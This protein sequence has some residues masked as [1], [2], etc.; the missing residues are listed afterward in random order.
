M[1]V[2]GWQGPTP[3]RLALAERVRVLRAD[4]VTHRAIASQLGIS[5]SYASELDVDPDGSRARARK[6][7]YQGVCIDCG[8]PTTGGEGVS[9]QPRRCDA[10]QR[11]YQRSDEGRAAVT[12]WTRD[13]I[14]EAI[15]WWVN[16]YGEP[17]AIPDWSPSRAS[18]LFD[19]ARTRR[20]ERLIAEKRV[21]WSTTVICHF[22]SWNAGIV[23][24]G[25]E[26]RAN[27]G[28]RENRARQRGAR[29]TALNA[30]RPRAGEAAS[31]REEKRQSVG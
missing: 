8:G 7:S 26:P 22:G 31:P 12:Y 9:Q 1:S 5:R 20:A 21:P 6:D 17:P 27:V 25:F 16:E 15:R 30:S 24:A 18:A 2:K 29:R 13:R 4:G 3:E 19:L 11:A 14:V 10:C 23:A 28:T